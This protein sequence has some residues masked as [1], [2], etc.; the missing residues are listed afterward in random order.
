MHMPVISRTFRTT[1]IF[2]HLYDVDADSKFNKII[3][4]PGR[5]KSNREAIKAL[6]RFGY[7]DEKNVHLLKI[8]Q[9]T[10]KNK[11]YT[12]TEDE[13]IRHATLESSYEVDKG[14]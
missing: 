12:M 13:F 14:E 4:V 1:E 9:L 5:Y 10:L 8:E 7:I 11:R 6:K 2:A 3:T